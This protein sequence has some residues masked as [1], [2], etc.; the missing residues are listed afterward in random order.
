MELQMIAFLSIF[1]VGFLFTII[2]FILG[3]L[4]DGVEDVFHGVFDF[5]HLDSLFDVDV[6]VDHGGGASVFSPRVISVFVMIFGA[7][8]IVATI[9]ELGM[10][11]SILVSIFVGLIVAAIFYSIFNWIYR[12]QST[13]VVNNNSLINH[14]GTV[15]TE[16]PAHG[17]GEV[18]VDYVGSRM[19]RSAKSKD[20]R[21]IA[22]N[23]NVIVR[24]IRG[25]MVIVDPQ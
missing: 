7:T 25:H 3:E 9:Q 21:K 10:L 11:S 19:T 8:G 12:Q 16:I 1:A 5:F 23:A 4:F 6:D 13:S 20:G 17:V 18:T 24:E 15:K 2:S 14:V 22:I